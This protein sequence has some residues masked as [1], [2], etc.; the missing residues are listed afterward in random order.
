MALVVE[1]LCPGCPPVVLLV[2]FPLSP[3]IAHPSVAH[4]YSLYAVPGH[5]HK[6]ADMCRE[7][8]SDKCLP[9]RQD[10]HKE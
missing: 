6:A 9:L 8:T 5:L 7:D 10:L 1:R 4:L 2:L 3:A